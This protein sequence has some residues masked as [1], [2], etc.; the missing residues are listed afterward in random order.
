MYALSTTGTLLAGVRDGV[1]TV[2]DVAS[3]RQAAR[4]EGVSA[5]ARQAAL[6]HDGS[7]LAV[8]DERSVR[9]W[10]VRSGR[11]DGAGFGGGF[12]FLAPGSMRFSP[13]GR[14]LHLPS[15]T[16]DAVEPAWIDLR[17]RRPVRAPGGG[18]VEVLGPGGRYGV[19]GLASEG[20]TP[21]R[22]WDLSADRRRALEWLS[23]ELG[24]GGALFSA[25][26]R[27]FATVRDGG[28]RFWDLGTGESRDWWV[29]DGAAGE[30]QAALSPDGALLVV[31]NG[32]EITTYRTRDGA[33]LSRLP[34]ATSGWSRRRCSPPTAGRCGSWAPAARC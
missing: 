3:G 13:D 22:L 31:D 25:D 5:G 1:A 30:G 20:A 17:T 24:V 11:P 21:V 14:F 10:D 29:G 2:W 16:G 18:L 27:T 7:L 6:N 12:S 28:V 15:G 19:T 33:R 23:D 9:L 26:G 8:R 4:I 32:A 34:F